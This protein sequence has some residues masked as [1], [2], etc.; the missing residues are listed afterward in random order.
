M[1]MQ[2]SARQQSIENF[3]YLYKRFTLQKQS[4]ERVP[5]PLFVEDDDDG[6]QVNN[7][8]SFTSAFVYISHQSGK[9][10]RKT[11]DIRSSSSG[12]FYGCGRGTTLKIGQ[13]N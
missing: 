13:T 11:A 7:F 1:Q 8:F 10:C 2:I 6:A 5:F 3:F 9:F 12:S 4:I